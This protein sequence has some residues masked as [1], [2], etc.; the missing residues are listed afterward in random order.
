MKKVYEIKRAQKAS[1]LLRT[2]STLF[3]AAVRDDVSLHGVTINRVELAPDKSTC[4]VYFYTAE[5]EES[6]NEKLL[7]RLILYKP[8]LRAALAKEI[9]SRYTPELVFKFDNAFEKGLRI[10]T[11]ISGLKDKGEL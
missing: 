3:S 2:I 6:F 5:G 8:S 4:Y 9:A 10:E 1:L 7:S 11:L